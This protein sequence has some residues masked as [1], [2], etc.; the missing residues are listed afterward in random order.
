[1]YHVDDVSYCLMR[2]VQPP[3]LEVIYPPPSLRRAHRMRYTWKVCT[4]AVEEQEKGRR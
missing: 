4:N 1:M 2:V 3:R